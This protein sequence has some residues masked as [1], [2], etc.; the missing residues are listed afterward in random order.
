MSGAHP[1]IGE[2]NGSGSDQHAFG[3]DQQ[4]LA[5][6]GQRPSRLQSGRP[7]PVVVAGGGVA[8]LELALAL[9]ELAPQLTD[10]TVLAPNEEFAYRPYA[11]REPFAKGAARRYPVRR[12]VSDAGAR[13]VADT[14]A[15]VDPPGQ[16]VHTE[17]GAKIDY[18]ALALAVGAHARP[19]YAHAI[20]IDDAKLDELMHGLVLDIEQGA[21]RRLAF[22]IPARMA[23]PLPVYEL[24]LMIASRAFDMSV[25][26]A[27]TIVTPEDSPLAIFGGRASDTVAQL[28]EEAGIRTIT[29]AYAEVCSAGELAIDPG[30]CR[31]NV[32]RIVALPELYGPAVRGVPAASHGFIRVDRFGKVPGAGPIFAAGDAVDFAVKHGGV[33]SQQADVAARSIAALAGADVEL[34]QFQPVL[35]GMLLTGDR[36]LY[37]SARI[38]GGYGFSSD[39]AEEP[40][41]SPA[42]K[43]V[44]RYL[45]PYLDR[46]DAE[47]APSR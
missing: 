11:V 21:V 46:L 18:G 26:L 9:H 8:A 33:S 13:L 35:Q 29:S 28:L 4:A 37:L 20:T 31:L 38:T 17:K 23:W 30:D 16:A 44:S 1:E 39:V 24:A 2:T 27:V 32:D 40:M 6:A 25:E 36:P 47:A 42:G 14:L 15:W 7:L 5:G 41:W 3:S 34:H 22:V 12:I 10:V 19:R 43:V 45:A